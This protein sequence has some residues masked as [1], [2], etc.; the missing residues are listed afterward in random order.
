MAGLDHSA[1]NDQLRRWDAYW[2]RD[3]CWPLYVAL[4][5]VVA[6]TWPALDDPKRTDAAP[7]TG[8]STQA[9]RHTKKVGR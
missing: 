1:V 7:Q 6:C 9:V 8:Q 3:V 4:L 2:R 5:P